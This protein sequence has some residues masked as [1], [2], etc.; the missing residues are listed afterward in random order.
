[1]ESLLPVLSRLSGLQSLSLQGRVAAISCERVIRIFPGW[2][3][4][5]WA[6]G[7]VTNED[8]AACARLS[9]L[10]VLSLLP[11]QYAPCGSITWEGFFRLAKRP[12][13]A[14]LELSSFLGNPVD[15]FSKEVRTLVNSERHSRGWPPLDLTIR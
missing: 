10:W 11:N 14:K 6:G 8:V 9:K 12:Q 1:V 13:L 15:Y 5:R 7:H 3:R 4:L 2:T